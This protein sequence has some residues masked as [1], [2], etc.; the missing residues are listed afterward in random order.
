M[1]RKGLDGVV[2]G[3]RETDSPSEP[4][5]E[6]SRR[7]FLLFR[8]GVGARVLHSPLQVEQSKRVQ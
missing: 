2:P 3:W 4:L 6:D 1:D 7:L 5:G 8:H